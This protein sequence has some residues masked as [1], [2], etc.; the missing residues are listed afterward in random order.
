MPTIK[1]MSF[2][3]LT[4]EL[5]ERSITLGPRESVEIMKAEAD[6]PDLLKK[7]QED[8]IFVIPSA[9]APTGAE[10]SSSADT[11]VDKKDKPAKPTQ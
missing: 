3:A 8:K 7:L 10:A 5:S 6:A 11:P 1:N 4:I 9:E 2:G